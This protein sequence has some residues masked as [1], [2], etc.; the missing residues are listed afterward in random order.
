MGALK[1]PRLADG[2]V[3]EF[4]HGGGLG[5]AGAEV[6]QSGITSGGVVGSLDLMG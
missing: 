2:L 5:V 1:C 3:V 4:C 6:T